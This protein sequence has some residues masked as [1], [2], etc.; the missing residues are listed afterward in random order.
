MRLAKGLGALV[1]LTTAV[2]GVPWLLIRLAGNPL[3][4]SASVDG[5]LQVLLTPDDG[6]V[7]I[8]LVAIIAW[9]AWLVFTVSV[10][11][12]LVAVLSRQRIRIRLPG[13]G[14]PQR[15]AG[16]LIVLVLTAFVLPH[17]AT[18]APQAPDRPAAA[19][20]ANPGAD[21]ADSTTIDHH[22][23]RGSGRGA[24]QD[25]DQQTEDRR[26][27]SDGAGRQ[28]ADSGG[29][30]EDTLVH[31]VV[32]G[33]D[34]WTLAERFYGE[35]GQWR[36]IAAANPDLLTGGP[37]RLEAGWRLR[38]PGVGSG[39]R[40]ITVAAGESLS[41]IAEREYGDASAWRKIHQ[42]NRTVIEDPDVIPVGLTLTLP[43]TAQ[44]QQDQADQPATRPAAVADADRSARPDDP[45]AETDAERRADPS[46]RP[47]APV[48]DPT[49]SST[50]TATP[51]TAPT[52]GPTTA[53]TGEAS[54]GTTT[55]SAGSTAA[56]GGAPTAEQPPAE[57][58]PAGESAVDPS[59][60]DRVLQAA[61]IGGVLAAAV[62]GGLAA[63]RRYQLH[64]RPVGRRIPQPPPF[65][66]QVETG[67]GHRQQ[68]L[69]LEQLNLALRAIGRHCLDRGRPLP[70]LQTAELSAE[71]LVLTMAETDLSAPVGFTVTG[72]SWRLSPADAG[73]LTEDVALA[74]AA[75]PY[76][77]L[78]SIGTRTRDRSTDEI[79]GESGLSGSTL[80]IN[81]EAAGLV[82]VDGPIADVDAMITAVCTELA[83]S[84]WADEL[85]ITV[86]GDDHGLADSIDRYNLSA[87]DDL[88]QV[89]SRWEQRARLQREHLDADTPAPVDQRID[90]D[91][92][93]P[94]IPEIALIMTPPTPEQLEQLK[95]LLQD[96]PPVTMAAVLPG[97]GPDWKIEIEDPADSTECR[98]DGPGAK[99][100]RAALLSPTGLRFRPQ[101]IT[102]PLAEPLRQLIDTTGRPQT[103]PAP[104]WAADFPPGTPGPSRARTDIEQGH[105]EDDHAADPAAR[106]VPAAG[107]PSAAV[108]PLDSAIAEQPE[109][110][111]SGRG[112]E[113]SVIVPSP[114]A[115][116]APP[117]PRHPTIQLLGPIDLI[118][119]TG[120][121][122]NR[123]VLQCIEYCTWLLENPGSTAQ[124]MAAALAVA[125]G[126]RR[127]NV[128]RLRTWLGSDDLGDPYLPDAYSGR[129]MLSPYVS[130]DWHRL[131]I[132][133]GSGVN[134][135]STEGLCRALEL[136]RGAPLADAAPG[137]WHWAEEMRTDM[138][139]VIRDIGVELTSRALE[140]GDL[141]LARWAAAR[142][143]T[144]A[145]QD[146]FL[147][148]M[149]IRT[150]HQAGNPAEVE[151]LALQLSA[152]SRA[153]GVDLHP[154]TVDLLQQV[155]EGGL[156]ARA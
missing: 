19:A 93:D 135:C 103:E 35:G 22:S 75:Q 149:R 111:R 49:G 119:T 131:Q 125:E 132:L 1:V 16:G 137:Q 112:S 144:A 113:E 7:L 63:R 109:P 143:L 138:V 136:V 84:P 123:A 126:T 97:A 156:R 45:D 89:I 17:Q 60:A 122:P 78:T 153:L 71:E 147:V 134:R 37:D 18:A 3:P 110:D 2:L 86:V 53:P 104:W 139:S 102:E 10:F 11:T 43:G 152:H 116:S 81:L 34:L 25:R 88:D 130:S 50:P 38:I 47:S 52:T 150:E 56:A 66:Q 133:T 124:A 31:T 30:T 98:T 24:G 90:P 55:A 59:A 99:A 33:D 146:E 73:F 21:A 145:P 96:G 61:G 95:N 8:R 13:L 68:P 83:F 107:W 40:Q 70:T 42:A 48:P 20:S 29:G 121:R 92:A 140:D 12:E 155:M 117:A 87:A 127:S 23:E 94:W 151:R 65:A 6:T 79:D 154:D 54:T 128:S 41:S 101:L 62:L 74:D 142:S 39:P 44:D 129:I 64:A 85:V 9:I 58:P 72:R 141:D 91:R 114:F 27:R 15:V 51:T 77:A 69:G 26:G 80:L 105:A 36:R 67:L 28:A 5:L 46:A 32:R 76:P 120:T 108:R 118:G 57:P 106:A 148:C 115:D 100:D 4:T 82:G 14:G